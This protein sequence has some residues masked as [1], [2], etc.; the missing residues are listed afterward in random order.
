M[1]MWEWLDLQIPYYYVKTQLLIYTTYK[2]INIFFS[3]ATQQTNT[4]KPP[5]PDQTI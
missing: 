3:R 2:S 1:F 5:P 4:D